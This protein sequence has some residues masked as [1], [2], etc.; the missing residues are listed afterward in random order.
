MPLPKNCTGTFPSSVDVEKWQTPFCLTRAQFDGEF[1]PRNQMVALG[2]GCR[3]KDKYKD[4][5][6]KACAE[7]RSDPKDPGANFHN[8][9]VKSYVKCTLGRDLYCKGLFSEKDC[10]VNYK[11]QHIWHG[12]EPSVKDFNLQI[13]NS[14]WNIPCRSQS[15]PD[16]APTAAPVSSPSYAPVSSPTSSPASSPSY[17]PVSSPSY[18]PVSSPTSSPVS[19]PTSSPVSS[20]AQAPASKP[21]GPSLAL[22]IIVMSLI[23]LVGLVI[24]VNM[25][26]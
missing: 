1:D 26:F 14:T 12:T 3:S 13:Y 21:P 25:L 20:P 18:A 22:I 7:V 2:V 23:L 17:A 19:S 4:L 15:Q 6:D 24:I 10:T 8:T 9:D 16:W 5:Y 11:P